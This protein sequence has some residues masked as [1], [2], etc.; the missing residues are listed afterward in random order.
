MVN[1]P[2]IVRVVNGCWVRSINPLYNPHIQIHNPNQLCKMQKRYIQ[3]GWQ[4][5]S[6]IY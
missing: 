6:F 4:R 3:S 1:T 5:H 2:Y